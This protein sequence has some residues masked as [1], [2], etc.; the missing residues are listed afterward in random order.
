MFLLHDGRPDSTTR[1]LTQLVMLSPAGDRQLRIPAGV[2]HLMVNLGD[3]EAQLINF[4]S[5]P[6]RHDKPDRIILPWDSDEL[7]VR[8]RDYLPKF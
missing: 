1:G 4:P 7:P 3:K 2:W 5:E 6:Y 8:V